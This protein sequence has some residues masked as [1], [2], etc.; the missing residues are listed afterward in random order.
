MKMIVIDRDLIC[1][2]MNRGNQ[3]THDKEKYSVQISSAE[4]MENT[5]P[6]YDVY[7]DNNN[8][9]STNNKRIDYI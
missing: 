2:I 4:L 7:G 5:N 3:C 8:E 9:V 6:G 1:Q